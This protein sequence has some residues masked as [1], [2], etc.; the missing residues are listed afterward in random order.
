MEEM[1]IALKVHEKDNVATIFAEDVRDGLV[2]VLRDP[3]GTE[4]PLR[5]IRDVPY[6]HKVALADIRSGDSIIKYGERIGVASRDIRKGEYVHIHN[7][8]S[9]RGRGDLPAGKE[10][11]HGI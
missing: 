1:K 6:G 11:Q 2:L 7:L 10:R 3:K 8:D 9:M 4:E 5:V